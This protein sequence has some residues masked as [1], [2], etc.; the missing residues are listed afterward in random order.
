MADGTAS[1]YG[2]TTIGSGAAVRIVAANAKRDAVSIQNLH[3]SNDL[4]VGPDSSVTSSTGQKVAAGGSIA[5]P[6]RG[7]VYGRASGAS[8]DVRFWEIS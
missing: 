7:D 2:A 5:P 1:N 4:Y 6:T 3:A 8:T